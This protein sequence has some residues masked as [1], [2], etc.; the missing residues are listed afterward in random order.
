[1]DLFQCL[2]VTGAES[3][4]AHLTPSLGQRNE[5]KLTHRGDNI[6]QQM[7]DCDVLLLQ[8]NFELGN[9]R[10]DNQNEHWES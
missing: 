3:T 5:D 10:S 1:M 8:S 4:L 9:V 6:G 2:I 7:R